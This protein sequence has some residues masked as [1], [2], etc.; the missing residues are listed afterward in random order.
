M[1]EITVSDREAL[2]VTYLYNE[3][4]ED[5][6]RR[7]EARLF[8]GDGRTVLFLRTEGDLFPLLRDRIAEVLCVG[9]KYAYLRERLNVRLSEKETKILCAALIAA[10]LEG[11]KGYVRRKILR[12][13]EYCLDGIYTF[14]L[15]A[16]RE[17]WER[18]LGYVPEAFSSADLKQFCDFLVGESRTKVY[19]KE[20]VL[21]GENF[22]PLRL[23]RLTGEED[24][25][26]EIVLSDAGFV[27]CLGEIEEGVEDFLQKFYAERAI[28]S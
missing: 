19:L 28:F 25:A 9:Y 22:T 26:T 15:G 18:I 6:K 3:L 27:Y 10:D 8:F 21:F 13:D 1:A 17:K 20:N 11:D 12:S 2:F 4:A 16:I 24:V 14:R 5:M 23:S 7:G